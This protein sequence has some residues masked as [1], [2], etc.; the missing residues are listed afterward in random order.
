MAAAVPAGP[1]REGRNEVQVAEVAGPTR[2]DLPDGTD[3][4]AEA[5]AGR[6]GSAAS[7]EIEY[8]GDLK[9]RIEALGGSDPGQADDD[10]PMD[11]DAAAA[12]AEQF[13]NG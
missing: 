3:N 6:P 11:D 4:G 10:A 1:P 2:D 8:V 5:G 13:L 7:E 9:A 12:L